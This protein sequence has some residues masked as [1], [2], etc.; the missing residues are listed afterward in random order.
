[1]EV[2]FAKGAFR[3]GDSVEISQDSVVLG[4]V[5]GKSAGVIRSLAAKGVGKMPDLLVGQLDPLAPL[6][7]HSAASVWS[8]DDER[9]AFCHGEN[10]SKKLVKN[11]V[12][13]RGFEPL[14][15][16]MPWECSSQL[17]YSPTKEPEDFN[18]KMKS[19]EFCRGRCARLATFV[20]NPTFAFGYGGQAV[21]FV[22]Y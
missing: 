20:L 22:I 15:P 3:S 13:L 16:P 12:E 19:L 1:M 6:F 18:G 5:R 21:I 10:C 17:S 8:G 2:F 7:G 11:L 14:T 9:E 4:N